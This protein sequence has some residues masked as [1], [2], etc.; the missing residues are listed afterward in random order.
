MQVRQ[1]FCHCEADLDQVL[2]ICRCKR[3]YLL[4]SIVV[5]RFDID[6]NRQDVV[7]EEVAKAP[8]LVETCHQ[9]EL[10]LI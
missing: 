7:L 5:N 3:R 10:N 4:V 6:L 1:P 8:V 9:P 2:L